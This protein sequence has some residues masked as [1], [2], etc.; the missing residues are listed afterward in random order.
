MSRTIGKMQEPR[1]SDRTLARTL[2]LTLLAPTSWRSSPMVGAR[3]RLPLNAKVQGEWACR[4][5]MAEDQVLTD[6]CRSV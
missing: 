6:Y 5:A 4:V 2:R 3:W 1:G